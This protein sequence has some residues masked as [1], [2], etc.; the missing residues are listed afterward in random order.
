[1]VN[2][3]N[4]DDTQLFSTVKSAV[5][6]VLEKT[7]LAPTRTLV[8]VESPDARVSKWLDKVNEPSTSA[9]QARNVISPGDSSVSTTPINYKP[10][11]ID[12]INLQVDLKLKLNPSQGNLIVFLF[13]V[14]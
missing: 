2:I 11:C 3:S 1:M 13:I 9:F 7:V 6:Q 8:E 12:E 4:R 10:F 5:K 14:C